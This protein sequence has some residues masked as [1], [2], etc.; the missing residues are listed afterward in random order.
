MQQRNKSRYVSLSCTYNIFL[1]PFLRVVACVAPARYLNI[2]MHINIFYTMFD[3]HCMLK[4][5]FEIFAC[6]PISIEYIYLP[7]QEF[8]LVHVFFLFEANLQ[9]EPVGAI[10]ALKLFTEKQNQRINRDLKGNFC[11]Y[12]PLQKVFGPPSSLNL[13]LVS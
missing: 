1:T 3:V 4:Q 2:L 11:T 6:H 7:F 9:D 5:M 12:F 8:L 13:A 10:Y